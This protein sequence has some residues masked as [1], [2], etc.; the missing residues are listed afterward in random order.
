MTLEKES[1]ERS[2]QA[3]TDLDRPSPKGYELR[4]MVVQSL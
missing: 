2:R 4:I 3:E 1:G